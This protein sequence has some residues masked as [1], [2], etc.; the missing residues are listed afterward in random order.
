MTSELPDEAPVAPAAPSRSLG[1]VLALGALT[2]V[3]AT[4]VDIG[5]P[6][7]PRIAAELGADP[8]AGAS[9]VGAHLLGY[10]SGQLVWGPLSD[11]YGRWRPLSLAMGG[12]ALTA[13]AC[14]LAHSFVLLLALRVLLGFLGGA[15]PV[16]SRAIARDQGGGHITAQLLSSMMIVLGAA[17]LLAP[18]VGSGLMT[19]FDWRAIFWFL[20]L[21]G[22]LV[23]L[24]SAIHV[25]PRVAPPPSPEE[26]EPMR[27]VPRALLNA[28][29][30]LLGSGDFLV[31]TGMT[32]AIFFGYAAF[33]GGSASVA[34]AVFGVGAG[35]FGPLFTVGALAFV[36]GSMLARRLV[37]RFGVDR[38]LGGAGVW[39]AIVGLVL[40]VTATWELSLPLFWALISCY[41]LAFG[42][43]L[44]ASTAKALEPAA[45]FAGLGSSILGALQTLCGTLGAVLIAMAPTPSSHTHLSYVMGGAALAS[46]ATFLL[47]VLAR[48]IR[49]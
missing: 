11:R 36:G 30:R 19:L 41:L 12:F 16:I 28:A 21:F 31:G 13:V 7:L 10:G 33:L 32:S 18:A 42:L 23:L 43:V 22:C 46:S 47:G 44:P 29:R 27:A 1:F 39:A 37:V 9:L 4:A 3:T 35:A 26:R 2:A 20:A 40:L 49:R 6:A 15:A 5:L 45:G 24:V 14:A 17:P 25:R 48:R 8:A 34:D 38:L